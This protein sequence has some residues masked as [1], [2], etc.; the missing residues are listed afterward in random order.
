MSAAYALGDYAERASRKETL[1]GE[2]ERNE[3]IVA[4]QA[5]NEC[6]RKVDCRSKRKLLPKHLD[7]VPEDS[8]VNLVLMVAMCPSFPEYVH[9]R[10]SKMPL[11]AAKTL[12]GLIVLAGGVRYIRN[13]R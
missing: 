7:Q 5:L 1:K 10:Q 2:M 11:L 12:F 9:R 3:S 13:Y 8:K 4:E 6:A